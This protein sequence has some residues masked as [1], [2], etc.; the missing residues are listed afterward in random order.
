[1]LDI[2]VVGLSEATFHSVH[3]L[4]QRIAIICL[5]SRHRAWRGES[6]EASG[7]RDRIVN[8]GLT[9]RRAEYFNRGRGFAIRFA[10]N[11][12][13][14]YR[15]TERKSF[16]PAAERPR[17]RLGRYRTKYPCHCLMVFLVRFNEPTHRCGFLRPDS[18]PTKEPLR[19]QPISKTERNGSTSH[20]PPPY[21]HE[22]IE[23]CDVLSVH[24]WGKPISG[25]LGAEIYG[26]DLATLTDDVFTEIHDAFLNISDFFRDQIITPQQQ[27]KFGPFYPDR[28]LSFSE[29][30]TGMSGGH[31]SPQG[32][33]TNSISAV[34]VHRHGLPRRT[35]HGLSVIRQRN[36]GDGRRHNVCKFIPG[37]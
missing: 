11:A 8:L 15:K 22:A 36:S 31:R 33:R 30:L 35:A 29:R 7:L 3:T 13:G 4:G 6:A 1:M 18:K 19:P 23:S 20:K 24:R 34:S 16:S 27:V 28:L 10:K 12:N 9:C 26:A 2:P 32:A 25:A 14:P 37:L 17:D 21:Y 5:T